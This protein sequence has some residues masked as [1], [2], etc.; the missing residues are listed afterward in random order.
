MNMIPIESRF[1][2][3]YKRVIGWVLGIDKQERI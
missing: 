2:V 3:V 1:G